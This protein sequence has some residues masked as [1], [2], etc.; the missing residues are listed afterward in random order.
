[1]ITMI[2]PIL[3]VLI[4]SS[5]NFCI[6]GG[7]WWPAFYVTFISGLLFSPW[8][9]WIPIGCLHREI[10]TNWRKWIERNFGK[11]TIA[12]Y[13]AG[14]LWGNQFILGQIKKLSSKLVYI[15][16]R[17]HQNTI[18]A[19]RSTFLQNQNSYS[20]LLSLSSSSLCVFLSLIPGQ[21]LCYYFSV[22]SYPHYVGDTK[23]DNIYFFLW[24][25]L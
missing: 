17:R 11:F 15:P 6:R 24:D 14:G 8:L 7:I 22:N 18:I 4:L 3:T 1:M 20:Q 16:P 12:N 21:K 9:D 10:S 19:W 25:W 23:K 5:F 2:I 13:S